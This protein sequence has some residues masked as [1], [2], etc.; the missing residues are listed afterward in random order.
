MG[1]SGSRC[2]GIVPGIKPNPETG[3]CDPDDT[4]VSGDIPLNGC[5]CQCM[6]G[7]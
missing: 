5:Y 7:G 6:G 3:M 2:V 1:D 4:E